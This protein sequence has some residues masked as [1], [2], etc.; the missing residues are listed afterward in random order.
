MLQIS[1]GKFFNSTKLHETL[2]RGVY[3]TNY[4]FFDCV[5]I[6]TPVGV[7]LPS[8]LSSGVS[9]L[10]YEV[11]E[12]IEAHPN[13]PVPGE[14][15]STGGD[16]VANDFAAVI[17]FAFGVTCTTSP[18]LTGRLI[19]PRVSSLGNAHAPS[20]FIPRMFDTSVPFAKGD[21][22]RLSTFIKDLIALD[23]RH[24]EGAMR[25]IRRYVTGAHRVA[26]DMNLAYALFVMAIE[27]LAQEFDGHAAEWSDYDQV[28]RSRID[29]A[30]SDAPAETAEKIRQAV[31]SN[32]H[33]ALARRFR[34]FT[35]AHV[36]PS[37]FRSEAA[38]LQGAISRPELE[39]ALRQSYE[40]RSGYVHRLQEI[41]GLLVGMP[42]FVD[43]IELEGRPTLTF[44]GLARLARHVIMQFIER[45]PRVERE[46]FDYWSALPHL[47]RLP[48]APKYWIDKPDGFSVDN[49]PLFVTALL[50]QIASVLLNGG[51]QYPDLRTVLEKI[52]GML[53]GLSKP[54]QR[55]PLLTLYYL[56]HLYA[57][58][59]FHRPQAQE[60]LR[61][62]ER[63]FAEPSI[64]SLTARLIGQ[65][66]IP[67][68]L[69][70]LES[71][72]RTYLQRRASRKAIKIG[73]FFE[74]AVALHL[75]ELQRNRS[76]VRA[77]ELIAFAV[78]CM[79]SHAGLTKFEA[80]ALEKPVPPVSWL[81]ILCPPRPPST[82]Q[83]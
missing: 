58:S 19:D 33:V 79:P 27:S 57:P 45:G 50:A 74:A 66:P 32:E 44:A 39:I 49:A 26:D 40:I 28:K 61:K 12:R 81:E 18:A 83:T 16:V 38:Q 59:E 67:W 1:T 55:L 43:A 25:A 30:L 63:D 69:D 80:A 15:I 78:E 2:Y 48:A 22:E 35:L 23:R 20:K 41:N 52:E 62:Y 76:Q 64:E 11:V 53:P 73:R 31:L 42:S 7:I 21:D 51:G 6:E 8:N 34:T 77:L 75:A 10:T 47:L 9:T 24:Y 29:A 13:S 71:L 65:I 82:T 70:E 72:Y 5:K 3:Y 46:S 14:V 68:T 17:S 37:Y 56:F 54:Q 60:L 4:R 36:A